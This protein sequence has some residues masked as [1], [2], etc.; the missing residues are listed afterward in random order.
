[1][2]QYHGKQQLAFKQGK[3]IA[4]A[5]AFARAERDKSI[6]AAVS[7]K[8]AFGYE[9]FGVLPEILMVVNVVNAENCQ[10]IRF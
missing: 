3:V 2:P 5:D 10:A 9:L 6:A 4:Y 8:K 1:M 7:A